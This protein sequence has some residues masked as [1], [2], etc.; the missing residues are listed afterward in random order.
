MILDIYAKIHIA[1]CDLQE[2]NI[3]IV[4]ASGEDLYLDTLT[5]DEKEALLNRKML[6]IRRKTEELQR[7]HEVFI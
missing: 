7:R 4:G 6:E 2:H 5:K 3:P 1:P